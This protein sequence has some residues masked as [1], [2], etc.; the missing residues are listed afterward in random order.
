MKWRINMIL[1][2]KLIKVISM[3]W[4]KDMDKGDV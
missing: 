3:E 2:P 1:K 4:V